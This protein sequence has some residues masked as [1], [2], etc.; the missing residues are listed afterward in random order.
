MYGFSFSGCP[1]F[2]STCIHQNTMAL[3][4]E[5]D[6]LHWLCKR[7]SADSRVDYQEAKKKN[8]VSFLYHNSSGPEPCG[9]RIRI[10]QA[11]S[12]VEKAPQQ[13]FQE[14]IIKFPRCTNSK[15]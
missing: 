2:I 13:L 6:M 10:S 1:I 4:N 14:I 7:R 9:I 11:R 8:E 5:L 15:L 12:E 3:G